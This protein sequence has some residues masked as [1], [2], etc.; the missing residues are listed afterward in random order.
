ML[1]SL[2]LGPSGMAHPTKSSDTRSQEV[3]TVWQLL[4]NVGDRGEPRAR[5]RAPPDHL[6]L[7]RASAVAGD[8][9]AL[10]YHNTGENGLLM[11]T[12]MYKSVTRPRRVVRSEF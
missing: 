12:P 4:L 8:R 5:A 3:P 1:L 7:G 2:D 6:C 9:L 11:A 10:R